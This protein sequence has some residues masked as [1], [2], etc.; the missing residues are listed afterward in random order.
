MMTRGMKRV[1][2]RTSDCWRGKKESK[3]EVRVTGTL[4]KT[5]FGLPTVVGSSVSNST[6]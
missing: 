5:I 6:P 2:D 4:G 3:L 1:E